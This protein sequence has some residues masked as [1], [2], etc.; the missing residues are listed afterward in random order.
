[1][2]SS[3]VAEKVLAENSE[4][5]ERITCIN[6]ILN[7]D[8]R[9]LKDILLTG[10]LY[11]SIDVRK[12]TQNISFRQTDCLAWARANAHKE[13]PGYLVALILLVN[14]EM[15]AFCLKIT[16][17]QIKTAKYYNDYI[18]FF[19]QEY[20][21]SETY[22]FI[23]PNTEKITNPNNTE[24]I[25]NSNT[26]Y[27]KLL[28]N[29]RHQNKTHKINSLDHVNLC[30]LYGSSDNVKL[31]DSYTP[32]SG[33]QDYGEWPNSLYE[34]SFTVNVYGIRARFID[35]AWTIS[36]DREKPTSFNLV[37]RCFSPASPSR[38]MNLWWQTEIVGLFKRNQETKHEY[39]L[40]PSVPVCPDNDDNIGANE[41]LQN[42]LYA[43]EMNNQS[44]TKSITHSDYFF[45]HQATKHIEEFLTRSLRMDN[46]PAVR[47]VYEPTYDQKFSLDMSLI[48]V[49]RCNIVFRV[50]KVTLR[51]SSNVRSTF[52]ALL[53]KVSNVKL[54]KSTNKPTVDLKL[55]PAKRLDRC[56][57]VRKNV[58]W[59]TLNGEASGDVKLDGQ[60]ELDRTALVIYPADHLEEVT[61]TISDSRLK[62]SNIS[63]KN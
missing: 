53:L 58:D 39:L 51:Y 11:K 41:I 16:T 24:K 2:E 49:V 46:K 35:N 4:K 40:W 21:C 8:T 26:E 42:R 50:C 5:I 15:S 6:F 23:N 60:L 37:R 43:L 27:K 14:P 56:A 30:A 52:F 9:S 32:R 19:V 63:V 31:L 22:K 62:F 36:V 20:I 47:T 18:L 10:D 48:D 38:I 7:K 29:F 12:F 25:T 61:F 13:A 3:I 34:T 55:L 44:L 33:R 17:P 1:M 59:K 28:D 45:S 54:L 57:L